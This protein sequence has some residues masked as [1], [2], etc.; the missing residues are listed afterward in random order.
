M[1]WIQL[2]M[3][4]DKTIPPSLNRYLQC[5]QNVHFHPPCWYT[6][7]MHATPHFSL[8]HNCQAWAS[9]LHL[10]FSVWWQVVR[11]IHKWDLLSPFLQLF[12]GSYRKANH[13][14]KSPQMA[15][16]LL[17]YFWFLRANSSEQPLQLP[18]CHFLHP[19]EEVCNAVN[20]TDLWMWWLL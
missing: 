20:V 15:L 18:D 3:V 19:E 6:Y 9:S 7:S 10:F 8:K 16:V 4:S 1:W 12:T 13:A 17:T 14:C 2:Q 11:K 5:T